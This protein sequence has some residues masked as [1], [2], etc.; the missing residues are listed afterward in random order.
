[1]CHAP[2]SRPPAPPVVGE[3]DSTG[4]LELTAA[5]G[6][7]L[8]AYEA[9]PVGEP[10]ARVVILPDIRGLHPYYRA[11]AE[12]FAEAGLH[13]LAIDYFGRTAGAAMRGEDF[14]WQPHVVQ[15]QPDQVALDVAA[16]VRH[17]S[18][19]GSAPVFTVGFCFGGGHSWRLAAG[20]LALAG[21]V[22]FYGR[23]G[24]LAD[25]EQDVHVPLLMLLA[26]ADQA[27]PVADGQALAAR[28]TRDG[29]QVEVHVYDGAPHGFFDRSF[30]EHEQACTDAWTRVLDFIDRNAR[31]ER[32]R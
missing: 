18:P 16:A 32:V 8:A 1:M 21:A 5:D 27:L 23:S 31:V 26:G 14:D 29:K 6:N 12:R 30:A 10:R 13:A 25:L 7:V 15:V 24:L 9:I 20:D 28:L 11:L 4:S 19:E 22:G 17:L 2:D 3:I